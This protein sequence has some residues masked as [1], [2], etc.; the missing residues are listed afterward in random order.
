MKKVLLIGD[1]SIG[2]S[3]Y[4]G[5]YIEVLEKNGVP[6]DFVFWNRH[7]DSTENLPGNSIPY[8]HYTDIKYPYWRKVLKIFEFA[9]F[10]NKRMRQYDYAY[11]VVFTI[12]HAVFMYTTLKKYYNGK[13]IFDIRDYSPMCDVGI[14]YKIIERLIEKSSITVVSSAG[15]LKWLPNGDNYHYKVA[16]NT[17]MGMIEGYY[18]YRVDNYPTATDGISIL[19]IGQIR[20]FEANS[21]LMNRLK[22][23]SQIKMVFA[24][25]G[26]ASDSLKKY[27]QDNGIENAVFTGRY[28]KKE[29][30]NIVKSH[31]MMNIFLNRDVNSDTLMTNRF[32]LSVLLR[33]PMIANEGSYQAD[34][35]KQYGLGIVLH[36]NDDFAERIRDWWR[37]FDAEQFDKGCRK[38]LEGVKKETREFEQIIV[39]L[40]LANDKNYTTKGNPLF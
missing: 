6:Y 9:R 7:M 19:T 1:S 3:P 32:Y 37:S 8:N 40:Y 34:L 13:Y 36:E 5:S 26:V 16:H 12:A 31:Q 27:A 25:T 23:L 17:N 10:A 20:D 33:K 21:Y 28:K 4:I 38:F 14:L 29:E 11:V 35:I 15:F 2:D 39:L 22:N 24:G 30:N 18:D